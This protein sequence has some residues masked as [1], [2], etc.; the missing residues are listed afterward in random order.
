MLYS[1]PVTCEID[2]ETHEFSTRLIVSEELQKTIFIVP[3]NNLIIKI[4]MY[5]MKRSK[6]KIVIII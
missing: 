3:A 4:N 6:K 5:D 1:K 2:K